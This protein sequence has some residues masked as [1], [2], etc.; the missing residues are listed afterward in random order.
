MHESRKRVGA[1]SLG[2]GVWNAPEGKARAIY[3][4]YIDYYLEY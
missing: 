2:P 1:L 4:Y 3:K